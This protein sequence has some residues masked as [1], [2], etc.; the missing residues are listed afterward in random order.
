M[1]RLRI[2]VLLAALSAGGAGE[3]PHVA[4]L[5][6]LFTSEGC[7]SCPAA[8]DLLERLQRSQ[9]IDGVTVIPVGL[10]VDYFN[11]LG[12][13][14]AFSTAAFTRRQQEYSTVFGPDSVYTPQIVVD[15]REAVTGS[16]D[17][18]VRR[19]IASAAARPHLPVRVVAAATG[20]RARLTI[21]LPGVPDA[22]EP[23]HA[24]AA[25]TEDDLTTVVKRG[26]NHGRT[27]HHAAVARS[28][29]RV[30][31]LVGAPAALTVD[32]P[33]KRAWV[34]DALRVVVWLEGE[35]SRAVYGAASVKPL[36]HSQ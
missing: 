10:H 28:V 25:I 13:K 17:V 12:W 1:M 26:E 27:L 20:D 7:S 5:V 35:R 16:D 36:F 24:V 30:G 32:L 19:A 9:P 2:A 6:E 4:V 18:A 22:A 15:G 34:P 31:A 3:P 11:H 14:D 33:I 29:R 21:D 23:V 8:D